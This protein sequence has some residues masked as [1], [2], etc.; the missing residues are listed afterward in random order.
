M[1]TNKNKP[2]RRY[3][4]YFYHFVA[5]IKAAWRKLRRKNFKRIKAE[6]RK[7]LDRYLSRRGIS[8]NPGKGSGPFG[9]PGKAGI[10]PEGSEPRSQHGCSMSG[11]PPTGSGTA[12][13][14]G[15]PGGR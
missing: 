5:E 9:N 1:N 13:K 7:D 6:R 10:S 11:M 2:K 12:G 3:F 8:V 15:M 4:Y 14:T